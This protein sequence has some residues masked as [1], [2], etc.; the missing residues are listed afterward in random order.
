MADAAQQ[1]VNLRQ[2]ADQAQRQFAAQWADYRPSMDPGRETADGTAFSTAFSQ[3]AKIAQRVAAAD[4]AGDHAA[5]AALLIGPMRH[6]MIV[7]GRAMDDDEAYEFWQYNE[8][9]GEAYAASSAAV[10]WILAVLAPMVA[11]TIGLIIFVNRDIVRPIARMTAVMRKL[12]QNVV[13][14]TIPCIG[15]RDELGAMADAV[16]VFKDNG[17]ARAV[18]EAEARVFQERLDQ[19]LKEVEAS[20]EAS[21]REQK[22]VVDGLAVVLAGLARGDLTVRLTETVSTAYQA[23]KSDFN[24]A[25]STLQQ[26]MRSIAENT[27]I[28]R[29]GAADISHASDDLSRRIEQQA[30]SLEQTAAALA[31]ITG[32]VERTAAN[33]VEARSLVSEA[34]GDAER[35]GGILTETVQAMSGIETSSKQI[36]QIIGVIDEIAFQTNLLALNAGVEAARAGDAGR[37]FAV[38][39][40]EVRA[41]AQR[42]ADAAKEIKALIA[43]S[44]AHVVSGVKLVDETGRAVG[45]IVQHVARLNT[46][47][48]AITTSAQEQATGLKQ[49]N[50][51]VT[52]MDDVTQKNAA[53][54]QEAS[55]ASQ[56]LA[57]EAVELAQL[58]GQ[59]RIEEGGPAESANR[60]GSSPVPAVPR[61][62]ARHLVRA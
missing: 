2:V 55:T 12:A 42:S 47:V 53:V 41:L 44:G 19:R 5:A 26:T 48:T 15:R 52:Q 50:V 7:F 35:S 16:K 8:R 51:A 36:G 49:V 59:L 14:V 46:L 45:S 4:S 10:L 57:D 11:A 40:T 21:G 61:S 30:A 58:V 25:M 39:A 34:Q 32:M 9:T 43:A 3:L 31:E 18:L 37:G 1:A 6:E 24:S 56:R 23:L 60:P 28:V 54:V 33:I 27:D 22:A 13:A 62:T 29:S 20:F 17:E 38:V